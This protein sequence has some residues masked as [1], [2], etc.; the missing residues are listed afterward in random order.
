MD[1]I[2]WEA[3][4]VLDRPAALIAFEGWGDAGS[5]SS[6]AVGELLERPGGSR[7][8]RIDPDEF[9]DFQVRRPQV[10][11]DE[12]GTRGIEWPDISFHAV[13][14]GERD[15][16]VVTGDEPSAR[17]KV[18]AG[19]VGTVLHTM[20]ATEVVTMGAFIGQVP[21]TLAVPLIGVATDAGLLTGY[22]LSPSGY[23]G[24]TG[25]VGVLNQAL[26]ADG[27]SVVSVWAAV[28]HYLSNHEYP[29]GGLALLDKAMQILGIDLDT[30]EM[31]AS[32][33]DY[34]SQVDVALAD[35]DLKEYV[36]GLEAESLTDEEQPGI[37]LVEEIERYLK[38]G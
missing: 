19:L 25:I 12:G 2:T 5:S 4:P 3:I 1:Q 27:F 37:R 23:E 10:E 9:Y 13:N 21:H 15:L 6:M 22:G 24:P 20:G 35:S 33:A 29:P 8:A 36:E 7:F 11:I 31:A 17:W 32:T 30:S 38:D 14:F 18:F 34:L 28:P 26:T 16:V